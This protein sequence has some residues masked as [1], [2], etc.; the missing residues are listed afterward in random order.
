MHGDGAAAPRHGAPDK[1]V[2]FG[3][4][5]AGEVVAALLAIDAEEAAALAAEVFLG[6]DG[7][8]PS[9]CAEGKCHENG[10]DG[11]ES[12]FDQEREYE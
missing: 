11:G 5:V 12:H 6:H 7:E 3:A 8:M 9:V 1:G 4:N 2:D 10:E